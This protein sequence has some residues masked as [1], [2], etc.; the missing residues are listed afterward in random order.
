MI[1]LQEIIGRIDNLPPMPSVAV[2]LIEAA[3]DPDVDLNTIASWISKDP[4]ITAMLL[5]LCNSSFYGF[6]KEVSSI[7][8]ATSLFGMKKIIQLALTAMSSKYLA[9]TTSGYDLATGELWKHSIITATAAEK[10]AALA[11]FSDTGTAFT[12]G[13][14]HDIGK[15][16][17]HEQV[18]DQLEK[19]RQTAET[20]NIGFL[21]AELK[22]LGFSHAEAGAL[23][24]ERW[25][26][27]S[28]LVD[29]VRFHHDSQSALVD[30]TLAGIVQAADGITMIMG[31]GM[32]A[33]GLCYNIPDELVSSLGLD[34]P[35]AIEKIM[36]SISQKLTDDPEALTPPKAQ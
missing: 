10:V 2:Q 3:N 13:L 12:A 19:I 32:G 26:F 35:G 30:P 18:G 31:L 4:S 29:A 23:L 16:I 28:K 33:D 15:I 17:I 20:G 36:M 7:R 5:R 25:N 21:N 8:Q 27:P 6:Q 1:S 11:G 9:G 14:L 34:K 24:M 22:V